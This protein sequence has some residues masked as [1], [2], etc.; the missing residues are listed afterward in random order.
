MNGPRMN[1]YYY[2][3]AFGDNTSY[4]ICRLENDECDH[5]ARSIHEMIFNQ[6]CWEREQPFDV[7]CLITIGTLSV[8]V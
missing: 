2:I 6:T 1:D 3:L 4:A 5:V 7:S 8:Y